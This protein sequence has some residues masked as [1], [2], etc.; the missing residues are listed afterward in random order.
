MP[1]VMIFLH[2]LLT[3]SHILKVQRAHLWAMH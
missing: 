2:H 1:H 3:F